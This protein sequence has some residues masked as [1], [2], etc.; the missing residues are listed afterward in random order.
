MGET[1]KTSRFTATVGVVKKDFLITLV[2]KDHMER[3]GS[4]KGSDIIIHGVGVG[5]WK[6]GGR[7]RSESAGLT[8]TGSTASA[9]A[10]YCSR[11]LE[12]SGPTVGRRVAAGGGKRG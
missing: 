4:R 10:S 7:G 1:L 11:W 8:V 9:S 3:F 6:F 2:G 5:R 12:L